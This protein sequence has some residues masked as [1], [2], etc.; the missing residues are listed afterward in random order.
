MNQQFKTEPEHRQQDIP[1]MPSKRL[2]IA[3][4]LVL[5]LAI[6]YGVY[7]HWRQ[8]A[9][10]AETQ[11]KAIN[12]VPKVR[13]TTAKLLDQPYDLVLPGETQAF[14]TASLYPR[15][16]GYI[17]ERRVDIGSRVK[18]GDLLVRI[19]AP[20][21][22]RQLDQARAQLQQVQAAVVQAHAQVDQAAANK[23]LA[24]LT[25]DRSD[26]LVKRGYDTV[27]NRDNQVANVVSQQATVETAQAGVKV[28]EANVEAQRATV[29]R[30]RTLTEFENVV[31]PF[32]GVITTRS[33]DVGDL[34]NADVGS[35]S[36][37]FTMDQDDVLRVLVNVPQNSA[38][39][40]VDGLSAQVHVAQIPGRTF[41]GKVARS[42][43]ALTSS[44]RTLSVEID[45][46]NREGVLRPGLFVN[47]TFAV[48]RAHPNVVI[49]SEALVFDQKGLH[50]V[51][52]MPNNKVHMQP[53]KI[54]R[55][56]GTSVELSEGLQG[57]EKI[58]LS[59]PATL[60]EG[61]PVEPVEPQPEV[62]AAR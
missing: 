12:F 30:L 32:D 26:I 59:P 16:T 39:G 34:V 49:P 52:L 18:K 45:V 8:N 7:A 46:D 15:A 58:V 53:I 25:F 36:P 29:E 51:V 10:A 35:R 23:K 50:A 21:L 38:N 43:V 44:A 55:D 60:I 17:A 1:P 37:L 47:V 2:F 48:P 31:A 56:F 61:S 27:Q 57:D 11:E 24:N 33:I 4:F 54:Y 20:D 13:F 5:A 28:A 3:V 6:G 19:A 42:S 40:I 62:Q 22:D 9:D 14:D 41:V